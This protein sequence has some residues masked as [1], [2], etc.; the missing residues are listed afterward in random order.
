MKTYKIKTTEWKIWIPTLMVTMFGGVIL[1][2][3]LLPKSNI[4]S[5]ISVL[6]ILL[7]AFFLQRFTSTALV[8]VTLT[9]NEISIRWLTQYIFHK[10]KDRTILLSQIETYKYQPDNNF[11]L[12]KLTMKDGSEIKLWH[13]V[14]TSKD[15]FNKLTTDF[16][17]LVNSFNKKVSNNGHSHANA[18]QTS[19]DPQTIKRAATIY[20]SD[21][22]VFIAAFAVI[23]IFAVPL[24]LYF[25]PGDKQ[26]NPFVL[27]APMAGAMFFLSQ[28]YRYRKKNKYKS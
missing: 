19:K 7:L 9:K 25:N 28:F 13:F 10:Y 12:F 22:A 4:F 15:D 8:E 26:I 2:N 3:E 27:L 21:G 17:Q 20:E 11:D 16:P 18:P 5:I 14:L 6:F 23:L 24:I 1:S